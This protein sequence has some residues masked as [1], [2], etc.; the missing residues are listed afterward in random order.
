MI[1]RRRS[2]PRGLRCVLLDLIA[3]FS[4]CCIKE[5]EEREAA[6]AR[7]RANGTANLVLTN[8]AREQRAAGEF[9]VVLIV[10]HR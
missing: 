10:I 6:G 9:L 7:V 5:L 3:S 8:A 1:G 4:D 2:Q